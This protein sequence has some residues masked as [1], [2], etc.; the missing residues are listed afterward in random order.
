[1]RLVVDAMATLY[2]NP[3][4]SHL[5]IISN[6]ADYRS[7]VQHAQ[8]L[9]KFVIV[10]ASSRHINA[11]YSQSAD[12][13]VFH[14]EL[15]AITDAAAPKSFRDIPEGNDDISSNASRDMSVE[16][17]AE[18]ERLLTAVHSACALGCDGARLGQKLKFLYPN[19][20]VKAKSGTLRNWCHSLERF[21]LFHVEPRDHGTFAVIPHSVA[22]D[23]PFS[24]ANLLGKIDSQSDLSRSEN[25]TD[26]LGTIFV[27]T[28][29][30]SAD[31]A[32]DSGAVLEQPASEPPSRITSFLRR[33]PKLRP[34]MT[35]GEKELTR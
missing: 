28:Q 2:T 21:G 23:S 15:I 20:D 35:V 13:I 8:S 24:R 26:S 18:L 33:F 25:V 27:E 9:G 32:A 19:F 6:D 12:L 16:Q 29:S 1:M 10:F 34:N 5:V 17:L 11:E 4:I 14:D 3:H 22:M 31:L 30:E 7:L